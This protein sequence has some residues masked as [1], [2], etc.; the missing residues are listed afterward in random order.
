LNGGRLVGTLAL[1]CAA[2]GCGPTSSPTERTATSSSPI[3]NGATDTTHTF[4]VGVVQMQ[5]QQAAFCSGALLAPN[6]VAT[7]RHCVSQLVSA[8]IDCAS[9]TFGAVVPAT[10][11]LVTTDA[12]ITPNSSFVTVSSIVVP[13][14]ANQNKV[15][16]NDIALLIL[17]TNIPLPQYVEPV[18]SP[19]MTDQ[20]VYSTTVTA[21]GYGVV[22]P[23]DLQGNTAGTRRIKQD[24]ALHCIPGDKT[25][26]DCFSD[27][28]AAQVMTTGEFIS[29]DAS[30]CEGDSGSSAFEQ[31]NFTAGKWV[32]FGILSRGGTSTDGQTCIQPIYSRFDAWASL[33]L[34][35]ANQAAAQGG[36]TAPPWASSTSS[37]S[38]SGGSNA[39]SGKTDGVSCGA[40]S[41]C[42]SGNCVSVDTSNNFVCASPCQANACAPSFHCTSGFCFPN[43]AQAETSTGHSG[44]CAL[45]ALQPTGVPRGSGALV[46]LGLG[47]VAALRRRKRS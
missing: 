38:S 31:N 46:G 37:S 44:G 2:V 45:S 24:I 21:I 3:Q 22:T 39:S 28:T 30:T 42:L 10:Q 7:A 11:M 25:F 19:P 5:G 17:A 36:Y 20:S 43:P 9:S 23:T 8:Q 26:P 16:G 33:L 1:V 35:A 4:A 32:S 34:D 41:E 29:G 27:P 40:D 6:L 13:T 47:A 15:C 18:L 14:G 12:T